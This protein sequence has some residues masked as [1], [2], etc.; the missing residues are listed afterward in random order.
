MHGYAAFHLGDDTAYRAGRITANP[1]PHIDLFGTIIIPFFLIMSGSQAVIGW[2]KP[3][4]VNTAALRHGRLGALLVSL[5]G[6]F[7]NFMLFWFFWAAFRLGADSGDL[8]RFFTYHGMLL[9][10]VLFMFNMLPLPPLDGSAMIVFFLPEKAARHFRRIGVFGI[11]LVFLLLQIPAVSV[12][13]GRA[14][15][16]VLSAIILRPGG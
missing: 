8:F 14:W 6:P 3:V 9:N 5:A 12:F 15:N 11:L 7:S 1:V 2:A 10:F 16:A 13:F 4:P